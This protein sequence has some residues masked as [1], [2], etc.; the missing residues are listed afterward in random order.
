MPS[1]QQAKR[2]TILLVVVLPQAFFRVYV[3]NRD[4]AG[5]MSIDNGVR[6]P[7]LPASGPGETVVR[8]VHAGLCNLDDSEE[9]FNAGKAMQIC[10]PFSS[11][12]SLARSINAD[13]WRDLQKS[14]HEHFS[15]R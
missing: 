8:L 6:H 3:I 5:Y 14:V 9:E 2:R 15:L 10:F 13:V 7:T 11:I 12:S 4:L 1:L